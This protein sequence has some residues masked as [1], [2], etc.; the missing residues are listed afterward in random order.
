MT[1]YVDIIH[2]VLIIGGGHAGLS[3]ALT[4]YRALLKTVVFD[5]NQPRNLWNTEIHLTPT[6]DSKSP[7][8]NRNAA[9]EEIAKTGFVQFVDRAVTSAD[10]LDDGL[11]RV[12][13]ATDG[14]ASAKMAAGLA[15]D[16]H[17]FTD[18]FTIYTNANPVL[19]AELHSLVSAH[20]IKVDDRAI[21]R[22][23]ADEEKEGVSID[24]VD[25]TSS[26]ER[27]LVHRPST[28]NTSP[29]VK[30]LGLR[31][32]PMGD[33][34]TSMPFCQTSVAGV[35]AAGDCASM[36]KIIPQAVSM[37]AYA[38]CGIAR[39]LPRRITGNACV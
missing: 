36:M 15:D 18:K 4:T 22:L 23:R 12:L 26:F 25:K 16:G 31:M 34:E 29:L 28:W 10:I 11:F 38:G 14:L 8:D 1:G 2:D 24:F 27:F 3:A 30:Q 6:W 32:T 20:G 13:D 17:R 39:E 37:G 9:R 35:F 19:A 33:I 21:L 7:S 5:T